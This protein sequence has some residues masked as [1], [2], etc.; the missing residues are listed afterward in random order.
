MLVVELFADMPG[1]LT[2]EPAG[3]VEGSIEADVYLLP[4]EPEDW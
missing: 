2:I 4:E 3:K 1:N